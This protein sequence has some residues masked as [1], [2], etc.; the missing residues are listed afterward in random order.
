MTRT[1][2]QNDCLHK[3]SRVIRDHLNESGV[4]VT[5]ETVKELILLKLGNTKEVMG[6]KVA[7]RSSKYKCT[8]VELSVAEQKAGFISMNEL[9]EKVLA[10]AAMDLGLDLVVEQEEE[11]VA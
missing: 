7:M 8:P 1:N 9:L 5:E 4:R 6:E 3:W 11:Q 10:W 2:P